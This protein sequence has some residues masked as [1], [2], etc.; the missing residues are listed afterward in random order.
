MAYLSGYGHCTGRNAATVWNPWAGRRRRAA[1]RPAAWAARELDGYIRKLFSWA[2]PPKRPVRADLTGPG[3]R[4][5]VP[6]DRGR[7]HGPLEP[8][9]LWLAGRAAGSAG[10]LAGR[11]NKAVAARRRAPP[12]RLLPTPATTARGWKPPS[13]AFVGAGGEEDRARRAAGLSPCPPPPHRRRAAAPFRQ[14]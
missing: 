4:F 10:K 3:F 11:A 6:F 5:V 1:R 12:A 13:G 7:A 2:A 8:S 9:R 14:G